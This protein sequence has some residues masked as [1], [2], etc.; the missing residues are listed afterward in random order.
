MSDLNLIE[1]GARQSDPEHA[2]VAIV[3]QAEARVSAQGAIQSRVE[4]RWADWLHRRRGAMST[5]SGS[6]QAMCDCRSLGEL[7]QIQQRW[8]VRPIG[9]SVADGEA[10]VSVPPLH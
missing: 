10:L 4:T 5:A 6:L 8:L 2:L 3:H 1:S 7:V 9:R